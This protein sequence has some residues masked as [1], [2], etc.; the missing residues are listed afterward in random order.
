M[1]LAGEADKVDG[2]V[3]CL[4]LPQLFEL[5]PSFMQGLV[6]NCP[7]LRSPVWTM[8]LSRTCYSMTRTA[9]EARILGGRYFQ[10]L[11]VVVLTG[12][13][14]DSETVMT[15]S[16]GK[17]TTVARSGPSPIGVDETSARTTA[18][19]APTSVCVSS[20]SKASPDQDGFQLL[21]TGST[22]NAR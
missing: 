6:L 5:L 18:R 1:S 10:V 11:W 15:G 19:T 13:K 21:A 20:F 22:T 4:M 8:V 16:N 2:L 17:Y 12:S 9:A 7:L 3:D 14:E